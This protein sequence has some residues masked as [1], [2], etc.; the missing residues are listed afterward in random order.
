MTAQPQVDIAQLPEQQIKILKA[1]KREGEKHLKYYYDTMKHFKFPEK[2]LKCFDTKYYEDALP[3]IE[4]ILREK[5][6][7]ETV[8]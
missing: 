4:R 3:H 7:I 8:K 1:I 6:E 5:S 2:R